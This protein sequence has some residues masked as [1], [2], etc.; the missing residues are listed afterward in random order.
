MLH[1]VR[2]ASST[3]YLPLRGKYVHYNWNC[4]ARTWTR[5]ISA[6]ILSQSSLMQLTMYQG[7]AHRIFRFCE[8]FCY[9]A[10]RTPPQPISGH[11]PSQASPDIQVTLDNVLSLPG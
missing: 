11:G 3:P 1:P 5:S 4:V 10:L 7:A 2:S 8:S 6:Y 9:L